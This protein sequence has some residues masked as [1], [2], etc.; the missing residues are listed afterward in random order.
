M[1]RF[2][3]SLDRVRSWRH[4]QVSLEEAVL[5]K[6]AAE[7]RAL[8]DQAESLTKSVAEA[9]AGLAAQPSATPAEFGA[10]ENYRAYTTAEVRRCTQAQTQVDQKIAQQQQ[11][12]IERRRAAEL[13]DRLRD[14]RH[15]EWT[16]SAAKEVEQQAEES[17]L[18]RWVRE[19]RR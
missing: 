10:L 6:L 12:L 14:R 7:R 1:K 5:S 3:F 2:T 11:I 13:L 19:T 18:A 17:Y 4:T 16:A 8:E 9:G 15:S